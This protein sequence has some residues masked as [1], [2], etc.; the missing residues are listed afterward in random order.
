MLMPETAMYENNGAVFRKYDVR[1]PREILYVKPETESL[2][3]QKFPD[4]QLWSRV[5]SP[6][7]GHHSATSGRINNISHWPKIR[8]TALGPSS[9]CGIAQRKLGFQGLCFQEWLHQSCDMRHDIN[10]NRIPELL[11]GTCI[12]NRNSESVREA[13]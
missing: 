5:L 7:P 8:E 13:H 10:N 9:E 11:V 12:R 3:M 2:R 1:L 6:Y 4:D